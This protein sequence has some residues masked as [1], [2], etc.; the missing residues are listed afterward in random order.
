MA[1][2]IDEMGMGFTLG[3]V[4]PFAL[5]DLRAELDAANKRAEQ[6]EAKLKIAVGALNHL[7]N[8]VTDIVSMDKFLLMTFDALDAIK[9][10]EAK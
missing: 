10:E 6:V 3:D 1:N 5:E 4:P 2:H 8:S 9:G 7:Y